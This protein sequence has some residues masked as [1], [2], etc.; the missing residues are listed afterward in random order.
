[1]VFKKTDLD[2][3]AVDYNI[4]YDSVKKIATVTPM[5]HANCRKAQIL[6]ASV[7]IDDHELR[8]SIKIV[9][10]EGQRSYE[11]PYVKIVNPFLS[12]D[13]NTSEDKEYKVTLKLHLGDEETFDIDESIKITDH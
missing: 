11:I 8:P 1:M 9:F 2:I 7:N 5:V 3:T 13:N 4:R 12:S 6:I 10:E